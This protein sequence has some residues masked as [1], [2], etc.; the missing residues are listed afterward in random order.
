MVAAIAIASTWLTLAASAPGAAAKGDPGASS[1]FGTTVIDLTTLEEFQRMSM[2]GLHSVRLNLYSGAVESRPGLRDWRLYDQMVGDAAR[3]G[4][5][6]DPMLLGIP[7]WES[8]NPVTLPIQNPGQEQQWF[9]FVRD[10]A[11]RYG[12][13]G[14]FWAQNPSIPARPMTNWE[15][16]NEPNIN[17]YTGLQTQVKASDFARVLRITRHAL[18]AAGPG[19]RLVLGG[20]Y[21]RPK[22]GHGV[23]MTRFLQRLYKLRRGEGLFDAVAIHPYAARARQI[24]AVTRSARRVMDANGDGRTPIF[25]SELGW[26]TGGNY[27]SQSLYR[28]TLP[29]QAARISST[30]RLL[31]AHRRQ[32]R[33]ARVHW[34]TWRDVAGVG[35]FW[36][37]YMGLFT[38]DGKPKPAWTA[39]TRV[40]G[41]VAGGP[42]QNF[43][44]DPL[45]PG[46]PPPPGGAVVPTPP[47]TPPP[48]PPPNN[49]PHCVLIIFCS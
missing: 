35:D 40:T 1:L 30:A 32:L 7:L 39:L 33:L 4:V 20:L 6:I 17:E 37:K 2:G 14:Y 19:N 10:V 9:A 29:E 49:G 11:R 8:A 48:A 13:G 46:P 18:N 31:L 28:A 24:L 15:I 23:R 22:P 21:R 36:D 34:H 12:P 47:P 26:T 16:W 42:L 43:G 44:R 45:P 3:G 25:I 5:S 27:W 41:G 38:S